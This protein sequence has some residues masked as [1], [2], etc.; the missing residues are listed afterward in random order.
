VADAIAVT[1]RSA[2]P[3]AR[4]PQRDCFGYSVA[5]ADK[6]TRGGFM[7][8]RGKSHGLARTFALRRAALGA[9]A[10]SRKTEFACRSIA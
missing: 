1:L 10:W 2:G 9:S 4:L 5:L 3:S 8:H 7:V 6:M